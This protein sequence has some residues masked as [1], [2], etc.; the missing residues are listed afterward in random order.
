MFYI[1]AWIIP[2]EMSDTIKGYDG[3]GVAHDSLIN[4]LS[5]FASISSVDATFHDVLK[6]VVEIIGG[7][8]NIL[9][10]SAAISLF[11]SKQFALYFAAP[12]L[13]IMVLWGTNVSTI[14]GYVLWV[15][16]GLAVFI[17]AAMLY[18]TEQNISC[19]RMLY[20]GPLITTYITG[21]LVIL[22]SA[23]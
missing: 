4:G 3:A 10:I 2:I 19:Q 21:A 18:K 13:L 6:S 17:M 23:L 12:G 8:P 16:T 5:Y 7:L 11:F 20:S 9:F 14:G 15:L 22:N 1:I